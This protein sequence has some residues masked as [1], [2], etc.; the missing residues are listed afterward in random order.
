MVLLSRI[1]PLFRANVPS[2]FQY[3]S[4]YGFQMIQESDCRF[5]AKNPTLSVIVELH[6]SLVDVYLRTSNTSDDDSSG[7]ID[8]LSILHVR[9]PQLYRSYRQSLRQSS[10][11]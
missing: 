2:C 8:L 10:N 7:L 3:L 1:S 5:V 6:Y 4:S 9:K 11:S